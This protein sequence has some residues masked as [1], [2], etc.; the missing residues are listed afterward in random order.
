MSSNE[1]LLSLPL[2]HGKGL[3]VFLQMLRVSRFIVVSLHG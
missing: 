1:A 3:E 2:G